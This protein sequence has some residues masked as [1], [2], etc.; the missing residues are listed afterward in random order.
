MTTITN[1]SDFAN[2][3]TVYNSIFSEVFQG[4]SASA[5]NYVK[6]CKVDSRL[7]TNYEFDFL[8]GF[9]LPREWAGKK[10]SKSTRANKFRIPTKPYESTTSVDLIEYKQQP[11][12]VGSQLRSWLSGA[13]G[14]INN[15]VVDKL[16][17]TTDLGYDGVAFYSTAHPMDDGSTQSNK[18]TAAL[19]QTTYRAAAVAMMGFTDTVGR[20]LG[21]VPK[22]LIVGPALAYVARD[23]IEAKSRTQGLTAAGLLDQGASNIAAASI[24]NV[25]SNDGVEIVVEP[26]LVGTAAN[27][28]FLVGEA[29]DAKP[30]VCNIA[31]APYPTDNTTQ[32]LPDNAR[33][34]FSIQAELSVGRGLWQCIYAGIV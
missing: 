14:F 12:L 33:Y 18:T 1:G 15:I 16:I 6:Y 13:R 31:T 10:I 23:I 20:P 11:E 7:G 2:A 9:P 28:W 34:D 21:I 27:Y 22:K 24:D 30:M 17:D 3:S 25:V 4:D 19:S 8:S 32:Y 29:A 26:L 5:D